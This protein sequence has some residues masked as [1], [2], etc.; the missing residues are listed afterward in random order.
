MAR[1]WE[2]FQKYD[3]LALQNVGQKQVQLAMIP[4]L[5]GRS[6]GTL[7]YLRQA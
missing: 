7:A 1:S 6:I 4:Q 2:K 3:G 5:I